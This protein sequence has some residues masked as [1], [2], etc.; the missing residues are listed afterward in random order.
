M[1]N[2]DYALIIKENIM[3]DVVYL[4]RFYGL[5]NKPKTGVEAERL[6]KMRERIRRERK[7]KL[8]SY[9]PVKSLSL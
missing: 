4:K 6:A 2:T 1:I 8:Y 5:M 9:L 3:S 7:E